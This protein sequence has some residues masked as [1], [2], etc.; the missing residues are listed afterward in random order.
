MRV[1]ENPGY[2]FVYKTPKST[3]KYEDELDDIESYSPTFFNLTYF[4]GFFYYFSIYCKFDL[5]SFIF[6]NVRVNNVI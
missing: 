3:P 1:P 4:Y 2:D 5:F 6:I